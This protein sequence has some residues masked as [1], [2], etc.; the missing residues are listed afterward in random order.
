MSEGFPDT[1]IERFADG[2]E[3][4]LVARRPGR[5]VRVDELTT[6]DALAIAEEISCRPSPRSA[7]T[8]RHAEHVI[9]LRSGS[10]GQSSFATAGCGPYCCWSR[11]AQATRPVRW[12]T[13]SNRCRLIAWLSK[14][15]AA[16]REE[17]A[18]PPVARLG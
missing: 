5:C 16:W 11:Q 12:T 13:R 4:R 15:S 1:L 10:T 18:D 8:S 3:R 14:V 9:A 6:A 7:C 17:L 2:L